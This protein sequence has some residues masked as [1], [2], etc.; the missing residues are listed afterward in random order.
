MNANLE[1]GE[2]ESRL[3]DPPR[4]PPVMARVFMRMVACEWDGESCFSSFS[5]A[6]PP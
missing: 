5:S 4:V 6:L 1:P 2:R 3:T